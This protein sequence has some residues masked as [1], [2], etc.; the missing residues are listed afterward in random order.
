VG[1]VGIVVSI[2]FGFQQYS[3]TAVVN[4]TALLAVEVEWL[5]SIKANLV[6]ILACSDLQSSEKS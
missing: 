2:S 5:Q 1:I 3:R 6:V 4:R